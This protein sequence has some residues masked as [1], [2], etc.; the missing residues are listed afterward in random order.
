MK[1]IIIVSILF[2]SVISLANDAVIGKI[3]KTKHENYG[4]NYFLLLQNN[5]QSYAY[6][7]DRESKIKDIHKKINKTYKV[8]GKTH[9]VKNPNKEGQYIVYY[10]INKAEELKLKDLG[11]KEHVNLQDP[12]IL[13]KQRRINVKDGR[14]MID[15]DV[16]NTAILAGGA[17]LAAEILSQILR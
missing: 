17:A 9:F 2:T 3:V 11:L 1:F 14:M 5:N 7:I 15:D 8:Y 10:Q 6:P 13:S 12:K 16:A 4:T